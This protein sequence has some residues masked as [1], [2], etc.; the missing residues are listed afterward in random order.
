M[1]TARPRARLLSSTIATVQELGVNAAGL[2]ELLK[3]SNASR[4]S[5]YQHFP[6]GKG[7]LVE[8]AT[9]IVSRVVHSHVSVMAEKLASAPSVEQWLDELF[10]F[11]REPLESSEYRLGSFMMAA[12]LDEQ[13]PAVQAAAGQAFTDWTSRLADGMVAAGIEEAAARSMAGL[14]LS[15]IEGAIVQSRA[16][17][18]SQP[19]VDARAQLSVLMGHHL[20]LG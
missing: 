4:N 8:T 15:V 12:A 9:R 1:T 7:Q 2:T 10:A 17:E 18:S 14:L 20:T 6:A 3:R 13:N 19:F 11:W 16:L 5:L